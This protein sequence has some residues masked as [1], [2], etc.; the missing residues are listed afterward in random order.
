MT[1][2][3]IS[4]ILPFIHLLDLDLVSMTSIISLAI[5]RIHG[6]VLARECVQH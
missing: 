5:F 2:W 1:I 6:T 3:S 4:F